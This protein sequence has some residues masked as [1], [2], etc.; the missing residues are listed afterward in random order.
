M[1]NTHYLNILQQLTHDA[2]VTLPHLSR[3]LNVSI[4][5]CEKV[6]Y[7][8]RSQNLVISKHGP[9]GGYRLT[10]PFEEIRIEELLPLLPSDDALYRGLA[11]RLKKA[12]LATVMAEIIS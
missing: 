7:Q 10:K 4:S 5:L 8:L 9:S 11:M 1:R 6:M 12:R 3:T 2:F